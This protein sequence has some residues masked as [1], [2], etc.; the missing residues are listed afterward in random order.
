M[1][2]EIR[3][4]FKGVWIPREIWLDTRLS[5]LDKCIVVEIDSLDN[6]DSG[7][8]ASNAYLA[9]FCQC[10]ER[11]VSDAVK[12]LTELGYIESKHYN[13]RVRML[14]SR[15]AFSAITLA[16]SASQ[17]SRICESDSQN[18][19]DN[20]IVNNIE[21]SNSARSRNF[22]VP[23]VD[24]VREYA[25]EKG[26]SESEFNPEYFIDFYGAKGWMIGK[27]RMKDWQSAARGWVSRYRQ[28]HP[29]AADKAED[30]DKGSGPFGKWFD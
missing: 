21:N 20:N 24:E 30:K 23:S 13:G 4:D 26:W 12:K 10:S 19:R 1:S 2:E 11:R 17:S 5:I 29:R 15:L 16:E 3:R 28:S 27:N 22:T 8:F 14:R 9:E 18:L 25:K 7:C 6:G